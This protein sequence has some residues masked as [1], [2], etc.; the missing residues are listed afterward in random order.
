MAQIQILPPGSFPSTLLGSDTPQAIDGAGSAGASAFAA[1]QDHKHDD[2]VIKSYVDN[3]ANNRTTKTEF[4]INF[5]T[6]PVR[7]K[8]TSISIPTAVVG[9]S[10]AILPSGN[11]GSGKDED[12]PEM[13]V[14][15]GVAVC[16][17][18]GTLIVTVSSLQGPITGRYKFIAIY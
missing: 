17:V 12:E 6:T 8:K 10:V 16:K 3:F 15:V 4:E 9:M 5:G 7:S 1:R 18:A 11:A 2:S 13:E 14:F